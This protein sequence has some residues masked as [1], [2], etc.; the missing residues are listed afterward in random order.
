MKD[1]FIIA[2]DFVRFEAMMAVTIKITSFWED[3]KPPSLIKILRFGEAYWQ[4][5]Y[6]WLLLYVSLNWR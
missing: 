6:V 1:N 3:A 4:H 2:T 5:I